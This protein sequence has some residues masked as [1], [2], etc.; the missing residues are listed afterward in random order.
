MPG[1]VGVKT[2]LFFGKTATVDGQIRKGYIYNFLNMTIDSSRFTIRNLVSSAVQLSTQIIQII[3][4]INWYQFGTTP[5]L[6]IQIFTIQI[7]TTMKAIAI[8]LLATS[9]HSIH[10]Q[11]GPNKDRAMPTGAT[12]W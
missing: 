5:G 10:A 12:E 4:I 11:C 7:F 2:S 3:H 9:I 6:E 8:T 1:E